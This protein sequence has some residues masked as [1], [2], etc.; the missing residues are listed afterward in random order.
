MCDGT[1]DC[2]GGEDENSDAWFY[3]LDSSLRADNLSDTVILDQ[4]R[5]WV[6]SYLNMTAGDIGLSGI[7]KKRNNRSF[8][9]SNILVLA[10]VFCLAV[11]AALA[12]VSPQHI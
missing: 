3:G 10:F 11:C 9:M 12:L 6:V 5:K 2:P 1:E 7:C 4:F 8:L